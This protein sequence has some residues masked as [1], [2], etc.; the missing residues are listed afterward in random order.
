MMLELDLNES[1]KRITMTHLMNTLVAAF[2]AVAIPFGGLAQTPEATSTKTS[3]KTTVEEPQEK[4]LLLKEKWRHVGFHLISDV[5]GEDIN[6]V[7]DDPSYGFALTYMKHDRKGLFDG[8]FDLGFQ[9]ISGFDTTVVDADGNNLGQLYVRNQL[10]HAHYLLRLTLFQNTGFQ[11]FVEGYGGVRGSLLGARLVLDGEDDRKPVN[12][13][14][15]FSANFNYG[16]AA[17]LRLRFGKRSFITARYAQMFS[18]EDGNVVQ[19]A[20]PSTIVVNNDGSVSSSQTM[21]VTLPPYSVR[22]GLAINL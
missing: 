18:L 5:P 19:V 4:D 9:P 10:A 8:G 3:T 20:D 22:V 1:P 16:Y 14:P 2:L 7:L 6:S 11:P 12:D 21:D 13:V 17:G 15:F